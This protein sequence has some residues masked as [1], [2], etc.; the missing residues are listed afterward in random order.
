MR[1][2]MTQRGGKEHSLLSHKQVLA[3]LLPG[4]L[5]MAVECTC[6]GPSIDGEKATAIS[7]HLCRTVIPVISWHLV[8]LP[9]DLGHLVCID[10][11]LYMYLVCDEGSRPQSTG[12]LYRRPSI[13][14]Q[15][16]GDCTTESPSAVAPEKYPIWLSRFG[17][18]RPQ[19]YE[20]T[21]IW[22][23]RTRG[24]HCHLARAHTGSLHKA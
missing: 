6:S 10:S 22:S 23:K 16:F 11:V 4:R 17:K 20:R 14:V 12:P 3:S 21:L 24:R 1:V 9:L 13:E 8:R 7:S 19:A 2:E 18:R 5:K 15:K